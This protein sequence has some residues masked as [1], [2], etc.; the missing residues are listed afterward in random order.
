MG[1]K[2]SF[3][4]L[5]RSS[6]GSTF[7]NRLSDWQNDWKKCL[8]PSQAIRNPFLKRLP[9]SSCCSTFGTK[10]TGLPLRTIGCYDQS[11][12]CK[13]NLISSKVSA[14]SAQKNCWNR[15]GQCKELSLRHTSSL[16]KLWEKRL[17]LK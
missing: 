4:A 1:E 3:R 6:T 11:E 16:A 8:F 15:S 2:G 10:R 9:D 17:P 14:R 13:Q 12:R 5:S 7:I